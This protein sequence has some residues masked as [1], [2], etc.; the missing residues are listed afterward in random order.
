[1]SDH[2][3]EAAFN[4]LVSLLDYPVFVVTTAAGDQLAGCL[5]GFTSQTSINPPRFLVG[6]SRNNHTFSV[7]TKAEHLAVHLLP[8]TELEVAELFGG[9]TG[10]DTD[11]FAQCRWHSGPAG[12]PILDAAPAWFVGKVT[13]RFDLG[14]HVGHLLEP[15]SGSAPDELGEVITFS[16]VGHVE[17]G[18][19]A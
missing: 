5:V 17:A 19:E 3:G 15:V 6:L 2:S 1:M 4:D 7:A 10:D 13:R 14:D 8:R 18:H 11:K 9:Q 16:D 12:M